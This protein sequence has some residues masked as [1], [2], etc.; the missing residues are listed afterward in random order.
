[1]LRGKGAQKKDKNN[2]YL[3]HRVDS[4]DHVQHD[5]SVAKTAHYARASGM[6]VSPD[7]HQKNKPLA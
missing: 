3:Q 7:Q 1:M 6:F 5:A 4:N 2:G